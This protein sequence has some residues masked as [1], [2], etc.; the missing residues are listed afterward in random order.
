LKTRETENVEIKT[1][2]FLHSSPS[3]R[4]FEYGIH[5]L[6]RHADAKGSADIIYLMWRI[7]LLCG[8]GIDA[9]K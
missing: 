1:K 4:W 6:L 2:F 8:S 9:T 5:S 3:K 7:S